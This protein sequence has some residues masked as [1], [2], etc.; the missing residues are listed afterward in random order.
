MIVRALSLTAWVAVGH[1]VVAAL[2]W[3]LL[4]VPESN[5]WMLGASA[6]IVVAA[7]ALTAWIEGVGVA[8]WTPGARWRES[9]ALSAWALPGAILGIVLFGLVWLLTAHLAIAWSSHRGEI[10]AWLMLHTGWARTGALHL[11]MSWVIVFLR[12][13]LGLSLA[14]TMIGWAVIRGTSRL[15]RLGWLPAACSPIRLVLIASVLFCTAW[16]PWKAVYWR[17]A[18]I[19]PNWQEPAFLAVKLGALYLFASLGWTVILAMVE[20]ACRQSPPTP[21]HP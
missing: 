3:F 8:A 15:W 7:I 12:C 11:A 1:A 2:L 6:L 20:R 19:E 14:V 10:D 5:A 17:P 9:L 13:V 4:Q 21:D 18:W 16:L